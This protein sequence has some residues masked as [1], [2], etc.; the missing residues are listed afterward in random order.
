[1]GDIDIAYKAAWPGE[2]TEGTKKFSI[3]QFAND[4]VGLL[5]ALKIEKADI[6]G[7][8]MG[9]FIA[10]EPATMTP[11][12]IDK[13]I[14]SASSCGGREA[15]PPSPEVVQTFASSINS[16]SPIQD[17]EKIIPLLFPSDWLEANQDYRNY[18][19]IPGESVPPQVLQAQF[20]AIEKWDGTSADLSKITHP[21]LVI[22]G[23]ED[24]FTPAGNSLMIVGKISSAWLVQIRD[25]GHGLMNEYPDQFSR[26]IS[27]F[28]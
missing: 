3:H 26:I 22:V 25:A 14:L 15:I 2:S 6:L 10:Q 17:E 27:T 18:M 13:L 28:P 16:S 4:T 12:R 8:S 23:T 5:D 11:D 20:E 1:V 19:P 9:S 21:T 7:H 24:I